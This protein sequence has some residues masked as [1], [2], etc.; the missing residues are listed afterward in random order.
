MGAKNVRVAHRARFTGSQEGGA[1]RR[2]AI[3]TVL[4]GDFIFPSFRVELIVQTFVPEVVG[5]VLKL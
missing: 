4:G 2:G 5:D 3:D 1:S